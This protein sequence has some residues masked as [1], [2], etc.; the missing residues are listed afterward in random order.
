MKERSGVTA[1]RN[2][3][4]HDCEMVGSVVGCVPGGQSAS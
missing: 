2:D 4:D 3:R 1:D